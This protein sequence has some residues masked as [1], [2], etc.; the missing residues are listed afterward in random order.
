MASH[1]SIRLQRD[2]KPVEAAITGA[3]VQGGSR[4]RDA[5]QVGDLAEV[6][7]T[8]GWG[9]DGVWLRGTVYQL[10]PDGR[11]RVSCIG[12]GMT[13]VSSEQIRPCASAPIAA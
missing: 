1:L 11:Y 7:D 8:D 12:G 4:R 3:N 9:P 5:L 2:A 6:F 13:D 10:L